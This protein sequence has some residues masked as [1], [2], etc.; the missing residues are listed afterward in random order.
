MWQALV[1]KGDATPPPYTQHVPQR[2][3]HYHL[4]AIVIGSIKE[5]RVVK[6][7]CKGDQGGS[8]VEVTV[9]IRP[10][11]AWRCLPFRISIGGKPRHNRWSRRSGA[12]M[13]RAQLE[14]R[15]RFRFS[16]LLLSGLATNNVVS[17]EGR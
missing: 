3:V 2:N 12:G 7:K 13:H 5:Q 6:G 8:T 1:A 11:R 16:W 4:V 17:V 14:S 9:P 15:V 10:Q